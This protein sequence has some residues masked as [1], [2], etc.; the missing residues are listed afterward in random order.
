M[1]STAATRKLIVAALV[2]ILLAGAFGYW[3]FGRSVEV[4]AT[5][6]RQ[7]AVVVRV[8]GPGTVQ[9]RTTVALAA[10][11]NGTVVEVRADVGDRVRKGQLLVTLDDRE[12]S[13]RLAG[14]KGQQAAVARNIEA[15]QATLAKAQADLELAQ[16]RQRRDAELRQQGFVAQAVVDA[17]TAALRSAVAGVDAARA[18]LAARE[19]DATTVANEARAADVT[20]T[21]ARLA[22]PIDGIVIQR[23]AE[24]GNTVLT[25]SPLLRLVDPATLWVATRVDESV[26]D[27]VVPGQKAQIRLRSGETLTG[28]VARIARLSDAATRELDVHVAF[29]TPPARFAIDQE[30]DV[31]I[32]TGSLPGIV[33]PATALTKDRSGQTGVLVIEEG[34]TR[35]RAV[36]TGHADAGV[37]R[38]TEGLAGGESVVSNA[39][40]VR[41]GQPVRVAAGG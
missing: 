30:A 14:V 12:S 28:R 25:G 2:I 38:V 36:R 11:V 29:D 21:Y 33:V 3:R 13:A 34:R 1:S 37:V 5:P 39:A 16:S 9:A 4:A 27:R 10:R 17:S 22:A 26:V 15:A 31:S 41:S 35:F 7:G 23:L 19:A 24:P 8:T 32:D 20:L 40:G 6:A 18:S